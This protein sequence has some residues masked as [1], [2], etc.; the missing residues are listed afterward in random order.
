M[1][2]DAAA[3][4]MV[5]TLY[6]AATRHLQQLLIDA[7]RCENSVG[8][9]GFFGGNK[10]K[11]AL[12]RFQDTLAR[13]TAALVK[14]GQLQNLNDARAAID[15]VSAAMERMERAYSCWP[16]AFEFWRKYESLYR[17]DRGLPARETLSRYE[18]EKE[19]L[20]RR[21]ALRP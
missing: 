1:A 10:F 8:K 20:A 9:T 15:A 19:I 4:R 13:C 18:R 2:T 5:M 17:L 7:E 21:H 16:V 14:D 3:E 11:P 12:S 6:P